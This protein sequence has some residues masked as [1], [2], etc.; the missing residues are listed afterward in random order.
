M[1]TLLVKTSKNGRIETEAFQRGLLEWWNT[2][3]SHG[4]SP[5]EIVF[6]HPLQSFLPAHRSTFAKQWRD[7]IEQRELIAE[8]TQEQARAY[9]NAHAHPLRPIPV[10]TSVRIQDP[11]T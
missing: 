5:I 8:M 4:K 11:K 6:G 2:P 10:R 9:Y 1:K 3:R 7:N